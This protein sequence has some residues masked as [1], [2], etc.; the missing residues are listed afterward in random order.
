MPKR[1]PVSGDMAP[2]VSAR[3]ARGWTQA[4]VGDLLEVSQA[5]ISDREGGQVVPTLS[6]LEKYAR[7]VGLSM[8]I[9]FTPT[10]D[11]E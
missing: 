7:I 10:G 6:F 3:M 5:Y 9:T 4:Y 2:L 11:K 8:R 1:R